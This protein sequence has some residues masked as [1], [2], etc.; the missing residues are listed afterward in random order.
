LSERAI[1]RRREQDERGG[2]N[3]YSADGNR[4]SRSPVLAVVHAPSSLGFI[5]A[6]R[7]IEYHLTAAIK[8][9]PLR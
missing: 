4:H 7:R 1:A 2:C 5:A 3:R 8:Q 6:Q 9:Q